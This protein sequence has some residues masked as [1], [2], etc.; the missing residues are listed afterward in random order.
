MPPSGCRGAVYPRTIMTLALENLSQAF[1]WSALCWI[2]G[3]MLYGFIAMGPVMRARKAFD[4]QYPNLYGVPG[5]H[6]HAD[7]FNA[8][9]VRY[10][11]PFF[12]LA[13]AS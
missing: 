11:F 5:V 10:L 7:E 2:P 13:R 3:M 9:Q 1:G 8:V 4:V 12:G 6:K